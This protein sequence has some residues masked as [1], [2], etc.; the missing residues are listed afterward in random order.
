MKRLFNQRGMID[1]VLI[2][3]VFVLAA[4]LGGYV[5]YRQQQNKKATDAASGGVIVARHV[6][7]YAGWK[8]YTS[9]SEKVTFKFPPTWKMVEEANQMGLDGNDK[10]V[11]LT[12]TSGFVLNYFD[13]IGGLGG[14][15]IDQPNVKLT[16][17]TKV[18]IPKSKSDIYLI[19]S[20]DQVALD[21]AVLTGKAPAVGDTGSCIY[22]PLMP[23]K[24]GDHHIAFTTSALLPS[25][26][27]KTLPAAQTKDFETAKLILKS[28]SYQ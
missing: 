26:T 20:G 10:R 7:P 21:S 2:I 16:A 5:Y 23:G 13:S 9:V 8:T 15:C 28:F 12:G 14:S 11:I 27:P 4:G 19:E 1:I 17:A 6:D 24:D 22:A 25:G 18:T 3:V